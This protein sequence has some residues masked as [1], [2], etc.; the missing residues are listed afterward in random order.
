MV[1]VLTREQRRLNMSRIRS[2]NTTP[3]MKVRR[4]CHGLGLR[5]RLHRTDLPGKP[6]LVFPR[7][8]T[9]IFVNGCFWHR[10][11]CRY[12]RVVPKT[13]AEFWENK[14]AKNVVRDRQ[15]RRALSQAEW[16]ILTIWE[17]ECRDQEV[18]RAR[19]AAEFGIR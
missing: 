15:N 10:H 13:N 17:C 8:H 2:R 3:E 6:D 18:L 4:V 19:I 14:R 9:V 16:K 1:D 7:F 5:Y 12:G 11:A